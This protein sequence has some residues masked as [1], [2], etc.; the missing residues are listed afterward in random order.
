[1]EKEIRKYLIN[2]PIF[3][4]FKEMHKCKHVWKK[5][6]S[7]YLCAKCIYWTGV[8]FELNKLISRL[9]AQKK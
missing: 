5:V 2:S 3:S 9:L 8:D 1:M 4:G 6:S 7:G